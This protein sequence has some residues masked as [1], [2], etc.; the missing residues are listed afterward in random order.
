MDFLKGVTVLDFSHVLSGPYCTMMLADYGADVLKIERPGIGDDTRAWGPPF[1]GGESCY[2]MSINRNKRSLTLD[3]KHEEGKRIIRELVAQSDV[4][5]ENFSPGTMKRLGLSYEDLKAI[6]PKLIYCSLSGYGQTGPD[7]QLPGFDVVVQARGGLMSITGPTETPSVVGI[8]VVDLFTGLHALTGILAALKGREQTGC[9]C[10][11]DMCLLDSQVNIL[12]HQ[13]TSCLM[14]DQ[15]PPRRVNAHN[16]VV[17][18]QTFKT[19]TGWINIAAG[20]D[21]LYAN[22][23]RVLGREDLL[24]DPRFISNSKRVEHR[25]VLCPL[26]EQ[27]VAE[28]DGHVLVKQLSAAHVPAAV[29]QNM[30]EVFTDPQVLARGMIAEMEHPTAGRLKVPHAPG[31]IDGAKPLLR[32]PPPTLGQHTAEVLRERLG[33]GE[34]KLAE[35][36][37]AGVV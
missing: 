23:C 22:L 29:V 6:N 27:I 19:K 33:Y 12:C 4:A 28:L 5:V 17:P 26:L 2:F 1:F 10:Y 8:S 14:T 24:A 25:T 9:G 32:R 30:R 13:G 15:V 20:N 35:L 18:Y 31:L 34:A 37:K 7:S 21:K 16:N 36:I 11:L 3:L